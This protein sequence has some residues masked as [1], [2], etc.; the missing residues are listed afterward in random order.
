MIYCVDI[1]TK[2]NQVITVNGKP[3]E[4]YDF[5]GIGKNFS[6]IY[7]KTQT[8]AFLKIDHDFSFDKIETET[9][10]KAAIAKEPTLETGL[11]MTKATDL[12]EMANITPI[13][14]TAEMM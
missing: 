4:D 10:I 3:I 12:L 11:Q 14:I 9:Q 13:D 8:K 6:F 7:N 1:E 2:G 5:L